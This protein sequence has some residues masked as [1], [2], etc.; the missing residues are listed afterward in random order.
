MIRFLYN[1]FI[2]ATLLTVTSLACYSMESVTKDTSGDTPSSLKEAASPTE[3]VTPSTVI[4]PSASYQNFIH[5]LAIWT[6]EL[7]TLESKAGKGCLNFEST[8]QSLAVEIS[9]AMLQISQTVIPTLV[10]DLQSLLTVLKT[11]STEA[12]QFVIL[13]TQIESA[14]KKN[15]A[16]KSISSSKQT[17]HDLLKSSNVAVSTYNSASSRKTKKL[18][19]SGENGTKEMLHQLKKTVLDVKNHVEIENKLK[20]TNSGKL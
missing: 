5:D 8:T 12:Q 14:M 9:N 17:P 6:Q 7:E 2:P 16:K 19:K 13:F 15:K 18:S 1:K 11:F 10:T 20:V 4:T 3:P